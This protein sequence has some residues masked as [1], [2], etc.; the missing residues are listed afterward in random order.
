MIAKEKFLQIFSSSSL[1]KQLISGSKVPY[2]EKITL[3]K[4]NEEILTLYESLSNSSYVNDLP[5]EYI[6]LNKGNGI[7]RII[8]VFT[9]KDEVL[10][11][12][13]CKMLEEEIAE[14]R[15]FGTFGGWRLDNKIKI[16]EKDEIEYVYNSYNPAL[17]V[18]AWK[19]FQKLAFQNS[20]FGYKYIVSFDIANF[21]DNIRLDVLN[22][23]LLLAVKDKV[24]IEYINMLK[25]FLQY[26]NKKIDM[27]E[28]KNV[29]LPQNEFGDQSRLLAN[30]YLQDYDNEIKS[31]CDERNCEYL[32]YSDDQIVF[33]NTLDDINFVL[34]HASK[35]LNK[36]GLNI[37]PSKVNIYDNRYLFDVYNC[38][39]I[40]DLLEDSSDLKKINEAVEKYFNYKKK[41]YDFK[42]P[43]ILKR[44]INIGISK[45]ETNKRVKLAKMLISK[46]SL[47]K[48]NCF[49]IN[50]LYAQLSSY[51]RKKIMEN[52]NE[53]VEEMY[54][55]YFHYEVLTFYG[56]YGSKSDVDRVKSRIAELK[57]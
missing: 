35:N 12:F 57:I 39:E 23:K 42:E 13:L 56:K 46:E 51:N 16:K 7:S 45:I 37:N 24:K 4:Y 6:F 10:Y 17:W 28:P 31:I 52:I 25:Y 18:K 20:Q 53:L 2:K 29:G 38:F 15:V 48:Y 30:F 9:L 11:Y 22:Q 41:K 40:M 34:Y 54:L 21:Y 5:R 44:I 26:W 1:R 47:K 50:K 43:T 19:E 36:I 3:E 49:Y 33:A 14:N 8:P 32:R 27:Y 55:N